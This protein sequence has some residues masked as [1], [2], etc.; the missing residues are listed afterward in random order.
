MK[1]LKGYLAGKQNDDKWN[2]AKKHNIH[3]HLELQ[4]DYNFDKPKYWNHVLPEDTDLETVWGA[5]FCGTW[6][7]CVHDYI[8]DAIQSSDVLIAYIN[9]TT[10]YGTIAEIGYASALGIPCFV[11]FD[12]PDDIYR[13]RGIMDDSYDRLCAEFGVDPLTGYIPSDIKSEFDK[14]IN[15]LENNLPKDRIREFVDTYWLVSLFPNVEI[16]HNHD[17]LLPCAVILHKCLRNL[18]SIYDKPT[19]RQL[20]YLR[21]LGVSRKPET[22]LEASELIRRA[23][24]TEREKEDE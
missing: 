5:G 13:P 22:K 17:D 12:V 20:S 9:C 21:A 6:R 18:S 14:T 23:K 19:S 4:G 7:D 3:L 24:K 2:W 1:K 15:D 8:I 10:A 16:W 11:F